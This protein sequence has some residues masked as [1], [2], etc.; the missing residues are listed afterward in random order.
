M[1]DKRYSVGE[2]AAITSLTVRTLQHYDNIGLLP[3][4]RSAEGGR[5]Y[6]TESDI[7]QLEQIQ[8]YKLLG[9]SLD[10]IQAKLTNSRSL[11]ELRELFVKQEYLL[12][13]KIEQL[14]TSFA[15]IDASL[16]ILDSGTLPPFKLMLQFVRLLPGDDVFEWAPSLLDAEQQK[17]MSKIF[18]NFEDVQRFYHILKSLLILALTLSHTHISPFDAPAQDLAKR[19]KEM[20]MTISNG[21]PTALEPFEEIGNVHDFWFSNDRQL[22]EAA[23][24]YIDQAVAIYDSNAPTLK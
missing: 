5:R 9:F 4:S 1:D 22:V 16:Q 13:R 2:M 23:Y 24:T 14:H 12:L 3:A 15:A 6:Y 21:D 7:I 18:K 8:F 20:M 10:E 17:E 11:E 19:W